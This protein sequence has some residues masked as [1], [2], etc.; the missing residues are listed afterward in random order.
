[1][2]NNQLSLKGHLRGK[3]KGYISSTLQKYL[4]K[5]GFDNSRIE[6]HF[7]EHDAV[8]DALDSAQKG[9]LLV[10]SNY[11]IPGIHQRLVEQKE[12]LEKE[13]AKEQEERELVGG[14]ES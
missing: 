8:Q 5:H 10:L 4:I 12:K 13:A 3:E 9:G 11:D 6:I 1:M 2:N 14:Y 7:D